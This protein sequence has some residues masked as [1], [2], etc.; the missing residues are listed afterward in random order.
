MVF[1]FQFFNLMFLHF[2]H[3]R[4]LPL[5]AHASMEYVRR[6]KREA[7]ADDSDLP[8][9]ST[10]KSASP[11]LRSNVSVSVPFTASFVQGVRGIVAG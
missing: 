6:S 4:S 5:N 2:L 7:E 10:S 9:N 3:F 8:S 1:S 11:E